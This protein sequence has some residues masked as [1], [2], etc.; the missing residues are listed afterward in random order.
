MFNLLDYKLIYQCLADIS[1]KLGAELTAEIGY[2][3]SHHGIYLLVL[4]RALVI[5]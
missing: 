2:H 4:Q 5:L 1:S 3:L